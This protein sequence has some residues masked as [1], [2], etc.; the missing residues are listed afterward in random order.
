M[1]IEGMSFGLCVTAVA[2]PP[3]TAAPDAST[4]CASELLMPALAMR[5]DSVV[6][7][8]MEVDGR[9]RDWKALCVAVSV[10]GAMLRGT[11]MKGFEDA[12]AAALRWPLPSAVV[13]KRR[14]KGSS[15]R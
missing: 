5:A 13:V 15:S 2:L 11:E 12:S 4:R 3:L 6:P 14:S 9:V 1:G 7:A 10:P 8:D